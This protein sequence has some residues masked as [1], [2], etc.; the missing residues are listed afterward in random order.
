MPA[1]GPSEEVLPARPAAHL[2]PGLD[3]DQ[4]LLQLPMSPYQ[5]LHAL[6]IFPMAQGLDQS[7]LGRNGVLLAWPLLQL[8]RHCRGTT[9]H[10]DSVWKASTR[11]SSLS[12]ALR[13]LE[14]GADPDQRSLPFLLWRR[15][16]PGRDKGSKFPLRWQPP[17]VQ[18]SH[19]D[20]L[21]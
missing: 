20:C 13:G 19:V 1:Q 14:Q 15:K 5:P 18:C 3:E 9:S 6:Q 2:H 17:L 12:R 16:T 21:I 8:V 7:G 4:F 10:R 11:P